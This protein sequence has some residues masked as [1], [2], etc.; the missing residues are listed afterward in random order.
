L[1]ANGSTHLA[2]LLRFRIEFSSFAPSMAEHPSGVAPNLNDD[3]QEAVNFVVETVQE[4]YSRYYIHTAPTGVQQMSPVTADFR[5]YVARIL[6]H[7]HLPIST[8]FRGLSYL[9]TRM[10]L[11]SQD[12][13]RRSWNR[14]IYALLL[15]ALILGSKFNDDITF[16]N[17]SW[18]NFAQLPLHILN[19]LERAWLQDVNWTLWDNH[20]DAFEF[21]LWKARCEEAGRLVG[22][23][24][25]RQG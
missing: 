14:N 20:F 5:G 8:I 19:Y 9:S 2:T 4:L 23:E 17:R 6:T 10:A 7:T 16:L 24:F 1:C 11:L 3:I 12:P 25:I 15:I 22:W 13:N 21:E 18:A